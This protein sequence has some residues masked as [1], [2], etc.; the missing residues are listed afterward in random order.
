MKSI[1]N[2]WKNGEPA[3]FA[4]N[5]WGETSCTYKAV[6]N[7]L[8]RFKKKTTTRDV[9]DKAGNMFGM[10][11]GHMTA[12]VSK[13]LFPSAILFSI[14]LNLSQFD[15]RSNFFGFFFFWKFWKL[16]QQRRRITSKHLN[17][18]RPTMRSHA[19]RER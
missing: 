1:F 13:Q 17:L 2:E 19:W 4:G 10:G 6:V 9:V 18:S 5:L 15:E 3:W 14:G 7:I 8:P 11:R 16:K 12:Y